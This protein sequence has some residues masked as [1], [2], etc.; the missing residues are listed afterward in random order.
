MYKCFCW[1]STGYEREI[2]GKSKGD[3]RE[4]LEQHIPSLKPF[5]H[6]CFKRFTG[7]LQYI[8][9]VQR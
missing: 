9:I 5:V 2:Y 6:G 4:M 8:S 7:Y 3:L 1:S